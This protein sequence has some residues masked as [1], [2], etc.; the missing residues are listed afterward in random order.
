MGSAPDA[1]TLRLIRAA[2]C[3]AHHRS[4]RPLPKLIG[5][6]SGPDLACQ[7][8]RPDRE[9]GLSESQYAIIRATMVE[10]TF[11]ATTRPARTRAAGILVWSN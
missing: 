4:E 6:S 3:H 2:D 8:D 10:V 1:A 7:T 5:S 11:I 9:L